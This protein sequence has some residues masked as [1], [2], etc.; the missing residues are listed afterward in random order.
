MGNNPVNGFDPTGG[1]AY[2]DEASAFVAWAAAFF[3]GQ[4]PGSIYNDGGNDGNDYGFN[5]IDKVGAVHG[6]FG[7]AG[8]SSVVDQAW[9]SPVARSF[10]PDIITLGAGFTGIAGVGSGTSF[11]MNL[12]TRGKHPFTFVPT[13]TVSVG[14]G[15]S[16]DATI[17]IGE[18]YYT[19]NIAKLD[20]SMLQ[21][22]SRNGD[23]PTAWGSGG[24]AAVAKLGVTGSV[25]KVEGGYIMSGAV[26]IGGGLPLGELPGNGAGG[27]SNTIIIGGAY[28]QK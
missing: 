27:L 5:T 8:N 25:S 7:T 16:I 3:S 20:P 15:Y 24:I 18:S 23:R 6:N 4:N 19:G 17:N 1:D 2:P 14:G 28:K 9:N 21:T 13:T 11:E 10:V 26:N 12:V 22:D